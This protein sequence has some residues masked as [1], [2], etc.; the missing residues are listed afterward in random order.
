MKFNNTNLKPGFLKARKEKRK[1]KKK[2][3]LTFQNPKI[4]REIRNFVRNMM[5]HD[6]YTSQRLHREI[7]NAI[8][9]IV[10]EEREIAEENGTLKEFYEKYPLD[11]PS[12]LLKSNTD[13]NESNLLG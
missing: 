13:K 6:E 1:K 12:F 11:I 10:A 2:E 4:K 3:A 5:R 9:L 7:S 8:N